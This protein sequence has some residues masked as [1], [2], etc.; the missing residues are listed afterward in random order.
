VDFGFVVHPLGPGQR[1]L[2]GVRSFDPGLALAGRSRRPAARVVSRLQVRDPLGGECRGLLVAVPH[3][4]EELLTDQERGVAA[5]L[6][7]VRLCH[8][9]GASVVGL[10]AVAAVI[11]GQGKAV[12]EAAP[13]PVTTGNA[14]TSL[15]AVETLDRFRR[16]GGRRGP[17]GLMG[18]PGSVATSILKQLVARADHVRVVLAQP[19]APLRKLGERLTAE[20]PGRVEWVADV[21][22]VLAAGQVLVA[23]SSTGGRLPLSSLPAGA[24]VI[25]VA[26]PV[27]VLDDVPPRDDVLLLDGEFVRLPRP[28]RG[29]HWRTAYGVVTG[30]RR[31]IF[32]CFA[33]PMVLALSGQP[34]AATVGRDLPLERVRR[35]GD[36]ATAHGFWVDELFERGRPLSAARLASFA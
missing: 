27:D 16:R 1:A 23:A 22:D 2:L 17:V 30:Q 3:L 7:A 26:A 19:P 5:V 18:P 20:G 31:H 33:E 24:V 8:D 21:G 25:D 29:D 11:G 10:G 12:A 35:L 34:G 6:D 28:L 36:L 15:A 9:A 13:C 4:P 14:F 32:A